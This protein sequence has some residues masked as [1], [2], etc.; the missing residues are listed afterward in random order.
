MKKKIPYIFIFDIDNCIIGNIHY[1]ITESIL[2]DLIKM[3]VN[4]KI[5]QTNVQK[6][7]IL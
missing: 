1:P 7:L 2:L 4:K 5:Y 3:T 6:M